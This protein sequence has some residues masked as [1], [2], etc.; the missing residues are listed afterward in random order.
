M[1]IVACFQSNSAL[2]PHGVGAFMVFVLGNVY[3]ALHTYLSYATI[4]LNTTT[5]TTTVVRLTLCVVSFAGLVATFVFMRVALSKLRAV[6]DLS[7]VERL[8]WGEVHP[9]WVEHVV[10]AVFEWVVALAFLAFMATFYGDLKG[11]HSEVMVRAKE[12]E[13]Q[14]GEGESFVNA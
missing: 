1:T 7:R 14:G 13:V 9:G 10:S 2:V 11:L 3:C 6:V 4:R 5:K 12:K 8:H